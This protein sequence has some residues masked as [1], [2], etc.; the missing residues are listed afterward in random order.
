MHALHSACNCGGVF[1]RG[2][3]S[4]INK[5]R[6]EIEILT[7]I[8]KLAREN[9]R[10]TTLLY[11]VNLNHNLLNKYLNYL[12]EKGLLV[13]QDGVYSITDRGYEFLALSR[14]LQRLLE[15]EEYAAG[16]EE[17]FPSP[18]DKLPWHRYIKLLPSDAEVEAFLTER[19]FLPEKERSGGKEK[20]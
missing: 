15:K 2:K 13:R 4:S 5:R 12:M 6:S 7:E 9:P 11:R 1:V 17:G 19:G 16:D 20:R 3:K 8:L 14:K 10:K 18:E